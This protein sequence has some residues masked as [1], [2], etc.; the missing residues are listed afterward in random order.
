MTH[1][2]AGRMQQQDQ[3]EHAISRLIEAGFSEDQITS[4]YVNPPGQ[5]DM[6]PLGGYR[7]KSPGAKESDEGMARGAAA[8]GAIG[9]AV[10]IASAPVTGP[11]GTAVGALVGAHI[12]SLVG[13]L[14]EMKEKGEGEVGGENADLPRRS[15]MV[16]AVG[17]SDPAKEDDIIEVLES[18]GADQ[19][20]LAEGTIVD[21]NWED[22]NP[23][24][25][26]RLLRTAEQRS[27][28]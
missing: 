22:F 24:Q 13:S 26:P 4:F 28:R 10:G 8:G 9:A 20:E 11:V 7:D 12:G 15:G 14:S 6:F 2:I 21:G 19:I 1:I 23:L 18:I 27:S 16:V 25:P 3:V 5:H 17:V